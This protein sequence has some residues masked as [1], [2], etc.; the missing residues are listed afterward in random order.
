MAS[1]S[2][3]PINPIIGGTWHIVVEIQLNAERL[4]DITAWLR[5]QEEL[6]KSS[7]Y[8]TALQHEHHL[9]VQ[10][11]QTHLPEYTGEGYDDPPQG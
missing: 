6:I 3:P 5:Q 4:D 10:D 7:C 1:R 8:R 2:L 11:V 9:R